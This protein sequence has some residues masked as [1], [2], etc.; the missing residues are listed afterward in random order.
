MNRLAQTLRYNPINIFQVNQ[1]E[2][3]LGKY[4]RSKAK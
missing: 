2:A 4:H 3:I 1:D